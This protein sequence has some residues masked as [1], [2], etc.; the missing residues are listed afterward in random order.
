MEENN[1]YIETL[2]GDGQFKCL[3]CGYRTEDYYTFENARGEIEEHI[4]LA[5][6]D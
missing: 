5:H 2:S 3:I 4:K 6:E 1:K